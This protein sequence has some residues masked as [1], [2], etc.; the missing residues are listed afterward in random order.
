M[1]NACV[2]VKPIL[3]SQL[4]STYNITTSEDLREVSCE[5]KAKPEAVIEWTHDNGH[6]PKGVNISSNTSMAAPYY[7]T[8]SW[9]VWNGKEDDLEDAEGVYKCHAKNIAGET[10]SGEGE[11][12]VLGE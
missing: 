7:V 11:L 3:T 2:S 12:H 4:N 6:R 10:L 5:F 8:R 1:S 9:L